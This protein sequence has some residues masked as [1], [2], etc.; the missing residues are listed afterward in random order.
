M[1]LP[2]CN[3]LWHLLQKVNE[4]TG[5]AGCELLPSSETPPSH[6]WRLT[7]RATC[8]GE[9]NF[10]LLDGEMKSRSWQTA[11]LSHREENWTPLAG[12]KNGVQVPFHTLLKVFSSSHGE[13]RIEKWNYGPNQADIHDF[14]V[15]GSVVMRKNVLIPWYEVSCQRESQPPIPMAQYFFSQKE[16][17]LFLSQLSYF[18]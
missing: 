10:N 8:W 1:W 16:T 13:G 2:F 5:R 14:K 4:K 12:W 18:Q 15:I 9:L 3:F 17:N 11:P 6:F 7:K